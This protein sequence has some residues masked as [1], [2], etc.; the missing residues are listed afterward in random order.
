MFLKRCAIRFVLNL[1]ER[2]LDAT[3]SN[4]VPGCLRGLLNRCCFEML[5]LPGDP[6]EYET[7][8]YERNKY[9]QILACLADERP[10]LALETGCSIGVLT[11]LLAPRV[12]SLEA[13]DFSSVAIKRAKKRCQHHENIT[14]HR[15]NFFRFDPK[16][17]FD[18]IICSEI[19]Y[20][21]W[22]PPRVRVQMRQ[23]LVEWLADRG[24]L[25]VVWGGTRLD[26]DF[27]SFLTE[28]P[29]LRCIA[30]QYHSHAQRDYRISV[31]EKR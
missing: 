5:Y 1:Y 31:F 17:P 20:Y 6:W 13:F 4:R 24:K 28:T 29:R 22:E 2:L 7:S 26:L 14:F 11:D 21:F 23:K 27:D 18:F 9:Q 12:G 19:L 25:I 16:Q 10:R 15:T 8:Q 3:L 30:S